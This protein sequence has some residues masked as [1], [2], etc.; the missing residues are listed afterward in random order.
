MLWTLDKCLPYS[1]LHNRD[2]DSEKERLKH[3]NII[4]QYAQYVTIRSRPWQKDFMAFTWIH[5][6]TTLLELT[7]LQLNLVF[8]HG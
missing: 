3:S 7:F 8:Q 6:L 2:Y 1:N 4:P 5:S